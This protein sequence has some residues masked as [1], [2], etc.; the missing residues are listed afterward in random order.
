MKFLG[1]EIRAADPGL[2]AAALS[3]LLEL[4]EPENEEIVLKDCRIAFVPGETR[5]LPEKPEGYYVGLDHLA[6]RS[7]DLAYSV[8]RCLQRGTALK[9]GSEVSYNPQIWG[10]GMNYVNPL[11]PDSVG[12]EICQRLDLP[13]KRMDTVT[14]GLEHIGI[15][16]R[17]LASSIRFYEQFGFTVGTRVLNHRESDGADID[18]AMLVGDGVILETYEFLHMDHEDYT[19]QPFAALV[20]QGEE[21]VSYKGPNGETIL[22]RR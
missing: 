20:F 11:F 3:T 19:D 7:T 4:P 17:D 9:N 18:V 13:G 10:P 8:E 16:V 14:D 12:T 6:F 1:V 21:E 22:V 2:R 15:P 5:K